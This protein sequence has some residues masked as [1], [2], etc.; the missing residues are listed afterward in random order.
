MAKFFI[1]KWLI[2]RLK[3]TKSEVR[4]QWSREDRQVGDPDGGEDPDQTEDPGRLCHLPV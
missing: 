3:L 4:S 2:K 1:V